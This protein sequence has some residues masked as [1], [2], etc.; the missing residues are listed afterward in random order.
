MFARTFPQTAF[1]KNLITRSKYAKSRVLL[2]SYIS[3]SA[4]ALYK[5]I[6]NIEWPSSTP[7]PLRHFGFCLA[8]QEMIT[9]NA[10]SIVA[11]AKHCTVFLILICYFVITIL[12]WTLGMSEKNYFQFSCDNLKYFFPRLLAGLSNSDLMP[13]W[14]LGEGVGGTGGRTNR[15]GARSVRNGGLPG[16]LW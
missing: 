8:V 1:E 3:M 10:K 4:F 2:L 12:I 9:Q 14:E 13:S 15:N 7:P 11:Y 5:H 16:V 6:K